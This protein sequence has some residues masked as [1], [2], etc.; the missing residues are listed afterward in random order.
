MPA[1][2]PET[3]RNAAKA[4]LRGVAVAAGQVLV[5]ERELCAREAEAEGLFVYGFGR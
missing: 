2:G 5:V 1:I 3:I 4:Q